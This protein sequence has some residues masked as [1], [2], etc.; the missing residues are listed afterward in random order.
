MI[1]EID[2]MN[3][4]TRWLIG[5]LVGIFIVVLGA[6][7]T[8]QG[9]IDAAQ[10]SVIDEA[11]AVSRRSTERTDQVLERISV[12]QTETASQLRAVAQTLQEIDERGTKASLRSV[13]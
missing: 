13:D 5:G 8:V 4:N 11:K 6:L 10:N 1:K 7:A 2:K 3:E 12:Q 9:T